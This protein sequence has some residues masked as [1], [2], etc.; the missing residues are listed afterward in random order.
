MTKNMKEGGKEEHEFRIFESLKEK[1][2]HACEGPKKFVRFFGD[3]VVEVKSILRQ[4]GSESKGEILIIYDLDI[5]IQ[6]YWT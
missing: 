2:R 1:E 6:L 3:Y 5:E 4:G